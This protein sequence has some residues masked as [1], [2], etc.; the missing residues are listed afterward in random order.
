MQSKAL[1]DI[2]R[3]KLN[4]KCVNFAKKIQKC[5]F[6][7]KI[8]RQRDKFMQ[9]QNYNIKILMFMPWNLSKFLET[10]LKISKI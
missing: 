1:S 6:F 3:H 4:F 9:N 2:N 10:A 5:F 8:E 7:R